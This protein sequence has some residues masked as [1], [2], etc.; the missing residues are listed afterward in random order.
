MSWSRTNHITLIFTII[1]SSHTWTLLVLKQDRSRRHGFTII[2]SS[3]TWTLIVLKQDGSLIHEL[4][5]CYSVQPEDWLL[6]SYLST[7]KVNLKSCKF[8]SDII[9]VIVY[10]GKEYGWDTW[11]IV[12]EQIWARWPQ[13]P[14]IVAWCV[15]RKLHLDSWLYTQ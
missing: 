9:I 3:H 15:T 10:K 13:N 4:L 2:Q 7:L 8:K 12:N 14:Y 5:L 6:A 1:Q 11:S